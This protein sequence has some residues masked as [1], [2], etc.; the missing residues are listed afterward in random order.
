[1]RSIAQSITVVDGRIGA[2]ISDFLFPLLLGITGAT[3]LIYI[4][5]VVSLIGA[6]LTFIVIPEGRG[7]SLEEIN[8]DSDAGISPACA[9]AE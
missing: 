1:V 4:L 7:R 3:G 6:M 5:A 9:A 2:S 8:G